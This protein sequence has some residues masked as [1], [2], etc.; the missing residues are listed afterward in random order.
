[1]R[2]IWKAVKSNV[3]SSLTHLDKTVVRTNRELVYGAVACA[4]VG[5]VIGILLSPKKSTTIGSHNGSGGYNCCK[6]EGDEQDED[7]E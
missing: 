7:H 6:P 2:E 5:V 4:A 3:T 1:M